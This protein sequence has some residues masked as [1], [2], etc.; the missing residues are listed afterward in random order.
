MTQEWSHVGVRLPES[1]RTRLEELAKEGKLSI[2]DIVRQAAQVYLSGG[3]QSWE[4]QQMRRLERSSQS[5]STLALL[6]EVRH[7]GEWLHSLS[8]ENRQFVMRIGQALE[9]CA[10]VKKAHQRWYEFLKISPFLVW[11]AEARPPIRVDLSEDQQVRAMAKKLRI[12]EC[13]DSFARRNGYQRGAELC[14]VPLIDMYKEDNQGL[15]HFIR[16]FVRN[17]YQL[18]DQ[19]ATIEDAQGGER[20]TIASMVGQVK[21]G[22]LLDVWGMANPLDHF[23]GTLHQREAE[24]PR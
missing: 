1:L 5:S 20:S 15:Q 6:P 23:D 24:D 18:F 4:A 19:L 21:G 17:G 2:S 11:Y 3:A 8:E 13:N 7:S 14:G 10:G 16:A 22:L 12:V 9:S